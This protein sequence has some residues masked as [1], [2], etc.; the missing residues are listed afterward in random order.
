MVSSSPTLHLNLGPTDPTVD[1]AVISDTQHLLV[2]NQLFVGSVW[3]NDETGAPSPE[4]ATSW[5]ISPETTVFTFALRSGLTWTDGN[6]LT[7]YDVR[8][9]ILRSLD[10]ATKSEWAPYSLYPIQNAEEYNTGVITDAN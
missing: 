10:P 5:A 6:P 9:G 4:L 3:A 1:P 8:Y 2:A 7:A